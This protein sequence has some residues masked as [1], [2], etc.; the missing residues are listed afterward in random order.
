MRSDLIHALPTL[1]DVFGGGNNSSRSAAMDL[2]L[3]G[4][5]VVTDNTGQTYKSETV[6]TGPKVCRPVAS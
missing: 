1:K 2:L 3:F 5:F 6:A 4:Y